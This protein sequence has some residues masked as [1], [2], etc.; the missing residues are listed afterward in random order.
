[1]N[2]PGPQPWRPI[3]FFNPMPSPLPPSPEIS[4]AIIAGLDERGVAHEFSSS[5]KG[6]DPAAKV[7]RL[8]DDREVPYDLFVGIPV[9]R[10]P[11]VVQAS[12][13]T[14]GGNDGWVKVDPATLETP[15][16]GVYAVGD[17][18]DP[19]VPRAGTFAED[20]AAVLA[21]R[22][23]ARVRGTGPGARFAGRGTC[24]IEF[25]RGEVG[26]VVANFLG[27]P[28]PVLD[29]GRPSKELASEKLDFVADRRARWFG[30]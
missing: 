9:H 22:I 14:E 1:M 13:L 4:E 26:K 15:H 12:G 25:G 8:G 28:K 18:A 7:A 5:V 16:P 17:C 24:Y 19:P 6:I 21:E 10:V 27:G 2:S 11:D 23:A 30:G 3:S 20:G 29:F